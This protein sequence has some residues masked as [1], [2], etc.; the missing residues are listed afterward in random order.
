MWFSSSP[1]IADSCHLYGSRVYPIRVL[2]TIPSLLCGEHF[3]EVRIVAFPFLR[4][5]FF[6]QIVCNSSLHSVTDFIA[7][8]YYLSL[9]LSDITRCDF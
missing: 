3:G 9:Y 5:A 2:T 6:S 7:I 4:A 1:K 8:D